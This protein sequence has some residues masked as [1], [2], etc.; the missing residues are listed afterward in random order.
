M[1]WDLKLYTIVILT[2]YSGQYI[3]RHKELYGESSA[4]SLR[5]KNTS[6][7][8]H[9]LLKELTRD[10]DTTLSPPTQP[11]SPEPWIQGF[12][13]YIDANDEVPESMSVIEWW[14]V[15]YFL[16]TSIAEYITNS[17]Q[18]HGHRYPVWMTLAWDHLSIMSSSVSSERA[19]SQAGIT[20]SKLQNCL[21]GKF[22]EA[23]QVMKVAYHKNL[24][25]GDER[26]LAAIEQVLGHNTEGSDIE[27]EEDEY[28]SGFKSDVDTD[29]S[30]E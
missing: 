2:Y 28:D 25:Y 30:L 18:Y 24:V 14:G 26:H 20:L 8:I 13:Q 7:R 4:P 3:Q 9:G 10:E 6:S 15:S 17:L 5:R 1:V 29:W 22:V 16:F 19:F 11:S 27:S 21:Q 23:L 12:Q